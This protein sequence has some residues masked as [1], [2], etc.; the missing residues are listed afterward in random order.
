MNM[1]QK[2]ISNTILVAVAVIALGVL[3]YVFLINKTPEQK[4]LEENKP[5]VTGSDPD[6]TGGGAGGSGLS[7]PPSKY[8]KDRTA[9]VERVFGETLALSSDKKDIILNNKIILS[10]E[11]LPIKLAVSAESSFDVTNSQFTF[12]ILS[13][14]KKIAAFA[15]SGGIHEWGG[16]VELSS[17]RIIPVTFQFDGGVSTPKWND[18]GRYL[19]FTKI[20]PEPASVLAIIDVKNEKSF[21]AEYE[22]IINF[23]NANPLPAGFSSD[24]VKPY[25]S[26]VKDGKVYFQVIIT[27]A[28][29]QKSSELW[30][31]NASD[32]KWGFYCSD[33]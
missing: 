24:V 20:S 2:G 10:T 28:S 1:N 14:T 23:S 30:F 17:G 11:D 31:F 25:W 29:D 16:V 6:K 12:A 26:E 9:P 4:L 3:G 27:S 22:K 5:S 8:C 32:N 13:P 19:V 18:N 7:A 33:V 15:V 21:V